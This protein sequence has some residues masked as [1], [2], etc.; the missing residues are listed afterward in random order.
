MYEKGQG[1][2]QNYQEAFKYYNKVSNMFS[3]KRIVFY[4]NMDL[5]WRNIF[6]K[7]LRITLKLAD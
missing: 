5:V 4:T 3:S 2:E 1:V 6:K 7:L